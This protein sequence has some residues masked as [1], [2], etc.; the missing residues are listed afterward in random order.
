MYIRTDLKTWS[1]PPGDTQKRETRRNS[2]QTTSYARTQQHKR[3]MSRKITTACLSLSFVSPLLTYLSIFLLTH[4]FLSVSSFSDYYKRSGQQMNFVSAK[5]LEAL[6][7]SNPILLQVY[8]WFFFKT[9]CHSGVKDS[10][11]LCYL[12]IAGGRIIG[13][14]SFPKVLVLCEIQSRPGFELGAPWLF[15][16][17]VAITPLFILQLK[18]HRV[19]FLVEYSAT[20]IIRYYL[21]LK[22]T[23]LKQ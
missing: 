11:L 16:T 17:T 12:F 4:F 8:N 23:A 2:K 3:P 22:S 14:I 6:H 13:S 5:P 1:R 18:I 7:L 9:G 21:S 10:N 19:L 15:P 20:H